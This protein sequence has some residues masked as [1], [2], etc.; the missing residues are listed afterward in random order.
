MSTSLRL[1]A[2][3]PAAQSSGR[4]LSWIAD[5]LLILLFAALGRR[6]HDS[7]M[8]LAGL[9]WTA[10]PFLAAWLVAT[11]FTRPARTWARI[12]PSGLVVWL[13]TVVGG[14]LLRVALG[15]TAAVSFQLVTAGVL[16]FFL[17]GRRAL[18]A[19][20]LQW[21]RGRSSRQT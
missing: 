10:A 1:H 11:A 17:L 15:D 2:A 20:F 12:W 9:L 8:D 7:G 21:R 6:T 3:P 14:L 18:S 4:W 13:V 5:V 16:G 19:L